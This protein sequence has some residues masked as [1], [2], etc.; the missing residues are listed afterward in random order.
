MGVT[1]SLPGRA[2]EAGR[3]CKV[4]PFRGKSGNRRRRV[5]MASQ[6]LHPSPRAPT[7]RALLHT[8]PF[9][10]PIPPPVRF[11]Y[12]LPLVPPSSF[13]RPDSPQRTIPID[14]GVAGLAR[15]RIDGAEGSGRTR[16][17]QVHHQSTA[18]GGAPQAAPF[19]DQAHHVCVANQ[20]RRRARPVNG[21]G[22]RARPH[23][24]SRCPVRE[25][26]ATSAVGARARHQWVDPWR[27]QAGGEKPENR[28]Q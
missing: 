15:K 8:M 23:P 13:T 1:V 21:E 27:S 12:P 16:R 26:A 10:P 2:T 20:Q 7:P 19:P 22:N 14:D 9:S 25:E 17:G 6:A 28:Q 3:G 24:R 4:G 18:R 11:G 5:V